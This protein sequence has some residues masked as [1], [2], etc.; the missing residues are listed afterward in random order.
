MKSICFACLVF[1]LCVTSY[2]DED[3]KPIDHSS[4]QSVAS[5]FQESVSK[6]DWKRA[7]KCLTPSARN[8]ATFKVYS[9]ATLSF[10]KSSYFGGAYNGK[11]SRLLAENGIVFDGYLETVPKQI[12]EIHD[13][14]TLASLFEG[15]WTLFCSLEPDEEKRDKILTNFFVGHFDDFV[16]KE[17]E[18]TANFKQSYFDDGY[19]GQTFL[20]EFEKRDG[21]WYLV[22]YSNVA[23]EP[24]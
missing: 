16:I 9:I 13:S 7:F 2:A 8:H 23:P 5:D 12:K 15:L 22:R 1:S 14:D 10:T 4:P 20:V 6:Q 11:F 18:A 19:V 21:K 3:G 17:S 24:Q